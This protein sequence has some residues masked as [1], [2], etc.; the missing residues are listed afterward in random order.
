MKLANF[1][2]C[3]GT[4]DSQGLFEQRV[5]EMKDHFNFFEHFKNTIQIYYLCYL[6]D[7]G[8]LFHATVYVMY[9]KVENISE[10]GENISERGEIG[11]FTQAAK[12]RTN[13]SNKHGVFNRIKST[14]TI[15]NTTKKPIIS[16][17]KTR[18]TGCG[19]PV[20]G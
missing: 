9:N 19:T 17:Y 18:D 8:I 4:Q 16:V 1:C 7:F 14:V 12:K 2:Y 15:R 3:S 5:T 10:K 20:Q 6:N 13:T 11:A